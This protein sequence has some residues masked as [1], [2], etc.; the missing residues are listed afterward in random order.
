MKET[1]QHFKQVHCKT[2]VLVMLDNDIVACI[3]LV[4]ETMII[5]FV[6]KTYLAH[7]DSANVRYLMSASEIKKKSRQTI[8][9]DPLNSKA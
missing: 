7:Y 3:F 1:R 5:P 6:T 8:C 4:D 2:E 9:F